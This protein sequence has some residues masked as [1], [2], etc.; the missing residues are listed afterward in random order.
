MGA[1][2]TAI[3][4]REPDRREIRVSATRATA[5]AR[6][7]GTLLPGISRE[8]LARMAAAEPIVRVQVRVAN[9]GNFAYEI[10]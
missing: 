3:T 7:H 9:D 1:L 10:A 2:T 5:H 8:I 6:L 4:A